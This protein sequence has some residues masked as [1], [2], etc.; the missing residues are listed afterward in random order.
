MY[1]ECLPF[2][3]IPHASRLFL[4]YLHDFSKVRQ[5]YRRP[6]AFREWVKDESGLIRYDDERRQCVADILER[7]NRAFGAAQPTFD[8]LT[9]FRQGASMLVTGQQV[10]LFG[11]P[12]FSVLKALSAVRFAAEASAAGV[13]C[14]P[15]FWLA[16]EDH[17]LAEVNHVTIP[18]AEDGLERLTTSTHAQENAPV[19]SIT[20][21]QE[22]TAPLNAAAGLMGP[23]EV[24]DI[25]RDSYQPG[26]TLGGAFARLFVRLFRQWGVILLDAA[27]PRLHA[28]AE[29]VY[30]AAALGAAD[31]DDAL[32]Q[33]GKAL[34]AAGYHEQVKVT[35]SSTLLF[36]LCDGRRLP[37]HRSDGQFASGNTRLTTAELTAR[38]SQAPEEFSANV[39]LRPVVQDYLLPTLAYTG[40]PAEV[41]YFAQ[42]AVVYEEL[43]GRITPVLPR[44]SA[45]LVESRSARLLKK[46]SITMKDVFP[47]EEHARELLAARS[48]PS[49]LQSSFDRAGGALDNSL[50]GIRAELQ[51][52]DS[53]L[54][55]AQERAGS[56]MRYQ[57]TRLR[58]RAARAELRRHEEIGRHAHQLSNAFYPNKNLQEREIAGIYFLSR[59]GLGLL[60]DLYGAMQTECTDHQVVYL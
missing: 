42:A 2:A 35:P 8:A 60:H 44:F 17:D 58:T 27:D 20:L 23:S 39:L 7:Q 41:A 52:L 5:F 34:H 50:E 24:A 16:T 33:R 3:E 51:K 15:L 31:V 56:K 12:L 43:L 53:T 11:G 49:D 19:G 48:L 10:G 40:G 29:P 54:I 47:G 59:Y 26:A 25:L 13:P 9:R 55:G 21:G 28:V 18:T 36:A 1:C 6:P 38:I 22:I 30:R 46:Y 37:I 45:T 57:L 14:V 4:D 32:L